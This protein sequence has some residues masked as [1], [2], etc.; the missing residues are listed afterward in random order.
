MTLT[1]K[2]S[3]AVDKIRG[4]FAEESD[5]DLPEADLYHAN[6]LFSACAYT[7]VVYKYEEPA[8]RCELCS[9]LF[10]LIERKAALDHISDHAEHAGSTVNPFEKAPSGNDILE[11]IGAVGV[12]DSAES[13]VK[14]VLSGGASK[15]WVDH[16]V[17]DSRS[18][19][20]R[21]I[22]EG[23]VYTSILNGEPDIPETLYLED[24]DGCELTQDLLEE[25]LAA[26]EVRT[27]DLVV[28]K[29]FRDGELEVELVDRD[30]S[31]HAPIAHKPA[32]RGD[33][34]SVRLTQIGESKEKPIITEEE[35][36]EARERISDE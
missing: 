30:R 11:D 32:K 24:W 8:I 5:A 28:I 34:E 13:D 9:E 36:A 2:A 20:S 33:R 10:R 15:Y 23:G 27:D 7:D 17:P 3:A 29:E 26:R 31:R 25:C 21:L 19:K 14:P 18:T 12:N 1:E 4:W 6:E 16:G 35:R 22:V